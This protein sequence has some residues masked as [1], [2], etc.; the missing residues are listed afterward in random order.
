MWRVVSQE[1]G[2]KHERYACAAY[3]HGPRSP[4]TAARSR[5]AAP[6]RLA[7][8]VS[9]DRVPHRTGSWPRPDQNVLR[10]TVRSVLPRHPDTSVTT[11]CPYYTP[12]P[13]VVHE[14]IGHANTLAERVAGRSLPAGRAGIAADDHRGR[15]GAVQ[16]GVLVQPRVRCAVGGRRASRLW[17]RPAVVV[18]RDR[19][20]PRRRDPVARHRRDGSVRIRH[21][22]LSAGAVRGRLLRS[23]SRRARPVSSTRTTTTSS[24][25]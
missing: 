4:C 5:A 18:R 14:V 15:A 21:H 10:R 24:L 7:A 17:R 11:R 22:P 8:A 25:A 1:L 13:D 19:A 12:E 23:R 3:R 16:S 6:G 20:V 2:R 9:A